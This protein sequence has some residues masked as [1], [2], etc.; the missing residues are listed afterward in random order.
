MRD[1]DLFQLAL[2][3]VLPWMVKAVNFHA[4]TNGSIWTLTSSPA[5]A[6]HARTAAPPIANKVSDAWAKAIVSF[7]GERGPSASKLQTLAKRCEAAM[8]G[9]RL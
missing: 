9:F 7:N 6:S 2:G 1:T 5:V 8:V 3:L 4:D